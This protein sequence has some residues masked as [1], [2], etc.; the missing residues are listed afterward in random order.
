M[1][2]A[3]GSSAVDA[4]AARRA[5]E[6]VADPCGL[7]YG[8]GMTFGD[9]GMVEGVEVEGTTVTVRIMLD[10]PNCLYMGQIVEGME[11][12]VGAVPGVED[13][14]IRNR[15]DAIWSRE[16]MPDHGRR[17]FEVY[18]RRKEERL[19]RLHRQTQTDALHEQTR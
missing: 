3:A 2:K 13:V 10:D 8:N 17:K 7:L 1:T 19:E 15:R 16:M 11:T 4:S 5:A 6:S 9:L 18:L 14:V 12:A